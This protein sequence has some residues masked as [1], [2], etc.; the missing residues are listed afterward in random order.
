MRWND[1]LFE[2]NEI[3]WN[4]EQ[5]STYQED[6]THLLIS[7]GLESKDKSIRIAN[8]EKRVVSLLHTGRMDSINRPHKIEPHKGPFKPYSKGSSEIWDLHLLSPKSKYIMLIAKFS[9][10]R[11]YVLL[12]IG[13]EAYI[14]KK[15]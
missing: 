13:E 6:L 5:I 11:K 2:V 7:S 1:I 3:Q 8:E 4:V 10:E 15:M 14:N 12:S 9:K